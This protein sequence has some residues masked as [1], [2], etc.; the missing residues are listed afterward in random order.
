MARDTN[1]QGIEA[2]LYARVS[3]DEQEKE[4]F[5]IPAQQKLLRGYAADNGIRVL[6]E[7]VDVETAKVAGR[8][9]FNEMVDFLKRQ[10]RG[11]RCRAILVEKTDRLYRNLRDYVTID[12]L[13]VNV[14]FVKESVV[15]SPDSH[16]SEKFVH[17]I[18]V[19]MAK[20][21]VDNLGEEVKKGMRE[22]AE[23][24]IWPSKAPLGYKNVEGP[25][26]KKII[27][28]DPATAEIVKRMFERYA[29]GNYSLEEIGRLA[30]AEGLVLKRDG[31]LRAVVQYTMKL[32]LYYG[33]FRWKGK[34]YQGTHTPLITKELWDKVQAIR[35][36]RYNRKPRRARHNFAF[37]RMIRCGH[38]GCAL[39]GEL[40]KAKYTYYHCTYYRG[41]CPEP[42]V[43]ED[44]L[45]EKFVEI[46]GRL[47]FD[48]QVLD[49]VKQALREGHVD[50]QRFREEAVARL[51]DE[52]NKLQKRIDAMYVDKLDGKVGARFFDQK[53]AEWRE[54]Q[55]SL[56]RSID[57]HE[58]ANQSYMEEGIALLDLAN[59]AVELFEKQPAGEK[60]RLLDF[61]LSNC[62]WAN[63][64][65]TPEFRQPFDMIALEA[66]ACAKEKV[67]GTSFGDLCQARLPR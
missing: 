11:S 20:Q 36:Q 5:S 16:S 13:D 55:A 30:I 54:E 21:Y 59:R 19:L 60:R 65:L 47:Q 25:D 18:K 8:T 17:G 57:D 43:R 42:F 58:R 29:T 53:S 49:W 10:D 34:W 1:Y 44:V 15:L 63:G 62:T 12:E 9:G 67:A 6:R 2:V 33:D 46:L 23:Q 26:G 37:A 3:S 56:K 28:P 41:K 45:E 61:V 31:S 64:E 35:G 52:Y 32:P 4:G 27:I 51:Q 14:H 39:V 38:C 40:K 24:G 48:G 22:K 66:T 50:E 7:F